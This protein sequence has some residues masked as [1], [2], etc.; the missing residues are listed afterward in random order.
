MILYAIISDVARSVILN[1]F[2][3][4]RFSLGNNNTNNNKNNNNHIIITIIIIIVII[5]I[6]ILKLIKSKITLIK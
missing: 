5:I 1:I 3:L 6:G 4:V 2:V